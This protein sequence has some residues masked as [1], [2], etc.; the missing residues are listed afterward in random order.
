MRSR[1]RRRFRRHARAAS[2]SGRCESSTRNPHARRLS[3]SRKSRSSSSS[4]SPA[5]SPTAT[6]PALHVERRDNRRRAGANLPLVNDFH[7]WSSWSS[8]EQVDPAMKR[9]YS[10][11]A[12][13][14]GAYEAG[15]NMIGEG[16]MRSPT[17][18]TVSRHDQAGFH[19]AAR[20][21]QHRAVHDACRRKVRLDD[22]DVDDG[23]PDAVCRQ[24]D[25]RLR[26]H[27][28]DDRPRIET[29]SRT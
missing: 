20:G 23:W 3:W 4:S 17:R 14:K 24:A 9:T 19:Q 1:W 28:Y 7:T 2:K 21:P 6:G 25:R 29:G 12:N 10:G 18:H 5:S 27:G 26:Q 16:R 15:N 11:A 13:G 8:H 22:G